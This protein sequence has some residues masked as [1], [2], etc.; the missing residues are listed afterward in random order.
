MSAVDLRSRIGIIQGRLLASESGELQCSPG[1]QWREEFAIAGE[2]GLSHIELIAERFVDDRNPIWTSSG[3]QEMRAAITEHGVGVTSLCIDEPLDRPVDDAGFMRDLAARLSPAIRELDIRMIVIPTF[4]A[5]GFEVLDLDRAAQVLGEFSQAMRDAGA[6][7]A[8]ELAVPAPDGLRFLDSIDG[9]P[10]GA[11]YDTGNVIP[12][13][14]DVLAELELLGDRVW[15]VHAKDKNT[16]GYNV[17][18]G[19]GDSPLPGVMAHLVG[20][21]YDGL[22][23][24]EATR[25]ENPVV[26]AR[27][28]RDF[29]LAL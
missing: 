27:Q 23:S 2:I 13:G 1:D 15:H 29:L 14:F 16:R 21:G 7:L 9:P 3:R 18:F 28:H 10:V 4:E 24:M 25:G 5:S 11:S 22:I 8:L 19:T 20:R 6:R 17:R 26:T 12:W